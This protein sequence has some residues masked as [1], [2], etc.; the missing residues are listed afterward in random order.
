M[1]HPTQQVLV[2]LVDLFCMRVAQAPEMSLANLDSWMQWLNDLLYLLACGYPGWYYFMPALTT[3]CQDACQVAESALVLSE[4]RLPD[5]AETVHT[6]ANLEPLIC[7]LSRQIQALLDLRLNSSTV[8]FVV[9]TET[10][11]DTLP[12]FYKGACSGL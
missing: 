9:P 5:L 6:M 1:S 8:G 4:E 7:L 10:L 12:E 3:F 11:L 2:Q